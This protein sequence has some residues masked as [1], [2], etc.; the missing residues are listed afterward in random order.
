[1]YVL[2]DRVSLVA[3]CRNKPSPHTLKIRKGGTGLTL[4]VWSSYVERQSFLE[5]SDASL[6]KFD[7]DVCTDTTYQDVTQ[8]HLEGWRVRCIHTSTKHATMV[9]KKEESEPSFS[10]R[11]ACEHVR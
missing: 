3:L 8:E 1:V 7:I 11:P 4:D 10:K 6:G 9:E 5:E 2:H